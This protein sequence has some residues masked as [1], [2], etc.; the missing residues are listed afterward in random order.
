MSEEIINL[1]DSNFESVLK[2]KEIAIVDF[3]AEWC[4]PCK[5]FSNIFEDFASKNKDVFCAKVNVDLAKNISQKYNIMSIPT[6]MIFKK[7]ILVKQQIGI[8][9]V[10]LLEKLILEVK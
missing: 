8:L 7:G 10:D 4:G 5:M 1:E 3:W 2:E 6:I 9:P